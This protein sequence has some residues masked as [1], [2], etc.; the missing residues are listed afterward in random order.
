MESPSKLVPAE[1]V[2]HLRVSKKNTAPLKSTLRLLIRVAKD[3]GSKVARCYL[4]SMKD[5]Q[6]EGGIQKHV[7]TTIEI[8][9]K[10][11]TDALDAGIKI[12]VENHAGDL[13]SLELVQMI[14]RAGSEYVGATIDSGNAT[15]TL[16]NPIDT[17]L[18]LSPH[19]VSSGVRD[20]MVWSSEEQGVKVQWTAMGDGCTDLKTFGFRVE[21]I[22]SNRAIATRNYFWIHQGILIQ[23][24]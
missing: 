4:G 21:K 20:S 9:K 24:R 7:N 22:M 13:H 2:Q 1:S 6:G 17:L 10:V 11:R 23:K 15:W 14:E 16:E 5:R 8:L 12:A 3:V 19:A 18:N